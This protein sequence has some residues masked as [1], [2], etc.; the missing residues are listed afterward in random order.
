MAPLPSRKPPSV[1]DLSIRR[2]GV[3][4]PDTGF[5]GAHAS[6]S[7]G[8]TGAETRLLGPQISRRGNP[9]SVVAQKR[10]PSLRRR[11][12]SPRHILGDGSLADGDAQ[13]E[14]L[15]MDPWAR[16]PVQLDLP[17]SSGSYALCS[18][19]SDTARVKIAFGRLS[20]SRIVKWFVFTTGIS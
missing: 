11:S 18:A 9:V 16:D 2:W 12:P 17:P 5:R 3:P 8:H 7:A 13:L 15:A 14:Q 6:E 1:G 4:L 19:R 10:L 20:S